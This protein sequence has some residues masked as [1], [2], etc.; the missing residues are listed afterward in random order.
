MTMFKK[1]LIATR[2]EIAVRVIRACREMGIGSVAVYSEV[3]RNALH[4]RKADEAY[5]IGPAA[6]RES[7]LNIEKILA[8]AKRA[9]CDA[10]HPGYGFLSENAEFAA[11]CAKAKIH[12]VGP[13]PDQLSLFGDKARA[14]AHAQKCKV[15]VLPGTDGPV[16]VAGAKA[17]FKKHARSGIVLK[18]IAGGGGRGMRLIKDEGEIAD[19][20]ARASAEAKSAFGNGAL[21]AERLVGRARHIEVQIVGDRKGGIVGLGARERSLQRR[22]Q[23]IVEL[24]PSPTL[25]A[26]LRKK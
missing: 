8:V 13:T 1:I 7:Y 20:F 10:I 14:R 2:G 23:K 24:A 19:A 5:A 26:G 18:A 3:D 15:P 12:F 21:Y 25:A 6:A 4:V 9:K 16:D 17:F 22:S 11:A